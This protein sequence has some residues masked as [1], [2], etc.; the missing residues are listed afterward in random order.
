MHVLGDSHAGAY[1]PM[2][3]QFAADTGRTVSVYLFPGCTFID[4]R[5]PVLE[6]A[7]ACNQFLRVVV[8]RVLDASGEGDL[9]F[10]PSLRI[11]RY[12]DQWASFDRDVYE[13]MYNPGAL[14]SREAA[15]DD[16]RAWMKTLADKGLK[17]IFE[18]PTPIFKA[19]AFRCSDWFNQ[20]NPICVGE[21]RQSRA[22]LQRLRDPILAS[23]RD[24]ARSFP[25]V[26]IWDPFPELCP[27]EVCFT[28]KDTRPLFFDGD[29]LS[30]YGN[31]LLYPFFKAHVDGVQADGHASR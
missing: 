14:K 6:Q 8:Q 12:G 11:D 17:V 10:L 9:L 16:A 2:S 24:L 23:M 4:F 7:P 28:S 18:A 26:S 25:N 13:T 22:E 27:G 31:S 3:E 1:A 30:G 21:N 15:D 29:H 19:P 5:R 20:H